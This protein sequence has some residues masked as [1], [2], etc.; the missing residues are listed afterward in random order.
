[1]RDNWCAPIR[2]KS[3]AVVSG[4]AARNVR[5][6]RGG[7]MDAI[8]DEVAKNAA[9]EMLDRVN[10]AVQNNRPRPNLRLVRPARAA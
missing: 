1:M 3:G 6:A 7:G 4:G 9:R 5:I 10:A 8:L 2:A